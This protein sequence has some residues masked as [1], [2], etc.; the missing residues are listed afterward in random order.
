MFPE[1]KMKAYKRPDPSIPRVRNHHQDWLQ[2][3]RKGR[4]AGSNFDYGGPLTEIARL[5]IIATQLLGQ[6]LTSPMAHTL[7]P[8]KDVEDVMVE[9]LERL[10]VKQMRFVDCWY[11]D[12]ARKPLEE[13]GRKF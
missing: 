4:P 10:D 1:E 9:I 12:A 5:G 2:A 7:L 11:A 6:K 8:I 13:A 3:I